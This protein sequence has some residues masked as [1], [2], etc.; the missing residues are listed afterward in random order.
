MLT[1]LLLE[2]GV[3]TVP[4]SGAVFPQQRD[5][6]TVF[7]FAR[8]VQD[9]DKQKDLGDSVEDFNDE[10]GKQDV[11]RVV[12][13]RNAADLVVEIVERG[14]IWSG[15]THVEYVVHYRGN[16]V[17]LRENSEFGFRVAARLAA[18][19]IADWA[20]DYYYEV[21]GIVPV[22]ADPGGI[23][24]DVEYQIDR[25]RTGNA[26]EEI[27]G[28]Q[29]LAGMGPRAIGAVP[30]LIEILHHDAQ[31]VD[32]STGLA[33]NTTPG[34]EAAE[35]LR[36][37]TSQSFG[38]DQERWRSWWS[39][40]ESTARAAGGGGREP[41]QAGTPQAPV[42]A[43]AGVRAAEGRLPAAPL[44]PAAGTEPAA[45]AGPEPAADF[46][47]PSPGN[48]GT[49][50]GSVHHD[51]QGLAGARVMVC[52]IV[53]RDGA[54]RGCERTLT[55]FTDEA[56]GY[57]VQANPGFY[58][59]FAEHQGNVSYMTP[60]DFA[61]RTSVWIGEG[62]G[63]ERIDT[64]RYRLT[65]ESTVTVDPIEVVG[66]VVL[67]APSPGAMVYSGSPTLSWRPF[68]NADYYEVTLFEAGTIG[69]LEP[70]KIASVYVQEAVFSAREV[71][72]TQ[73]VPDE[74]LGN[75]A[76]IWWVEAFKAGGIKIGT[77]EK[78]GTITFM[79]LKTGPY[80][81]VTGQPTSCRW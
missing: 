28:A 23:P 54:W 68:A 46:T 20:A 27:R 31:M 17:E 57:S 58:A 66:K 77:S 41:A 45:P 38:L 60:L 3:L 74:P 14:G 1:L 69:D 21:K 40:R 8:A 22:A 76:Y 73:M 15:S 13:T 75:C 2:G 6:V 62:I 33:R 39:E 67:E 29:R 55:A 9:E 56:G 72:S 11:L 35:A 81:I 37:I 50:Q 34:A 78:P 42:A 18:E 19:R 7:C 70:E 16:R 36:A 24:P 10:I 4:T 32:Y 30:D 61:R 49:V 64:G 26:A 53:M 5:P 44:P 12:E 48:P 25:L 79:E 47:P 59:V 65:A 52:E 43:V 51:G 80:F 71:T 63:S